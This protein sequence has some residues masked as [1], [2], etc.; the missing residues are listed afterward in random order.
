M[1]IRWLAGDAWK[2]AE[3]GC[4]L[5]NEMFARD[6]HYLNESGKVGKPI[7]ILLIHTL[8]LFELFLKEH[9]K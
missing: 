6:A 4:Y 8:L 2:L 3:A 9:M 7:P 1:E 5:A